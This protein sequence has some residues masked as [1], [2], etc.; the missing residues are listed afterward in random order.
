MEFEEPAERS[1]SLVTLYIRKRKKR[2]TEWTEKTVML[3]YVLHHAILVLGEGCN[4]SLIASFPDS[5]RARTT[6]FPYCKRWKA[7]RGLGTRLPRQCLF[8]SKLFHSSFMPQPLS[9]SVFDLDNRTVTALSS[10]VFDHAYI[11]ALR[12]WG[13]RRSDMFDLF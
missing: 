13:Q 9:S 10:M 12:A 4:T 7:G 3:K 6:A 8:K 1:Q 2:Q 5:P 11:C